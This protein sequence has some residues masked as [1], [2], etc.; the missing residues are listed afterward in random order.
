MIISNYHIEN[1]FGKVRNIISNFNKLI[2]YHFCE[3]FNNNKD[4]VIDFTFLIDKNK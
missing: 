1:K 4:Q 3:L 2:I